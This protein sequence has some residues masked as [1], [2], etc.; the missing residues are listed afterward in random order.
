MIPVTTT[1]FHPSRHHDLYDHEHELQ[2]LLML[3]A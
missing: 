2:I 1:T 3:K